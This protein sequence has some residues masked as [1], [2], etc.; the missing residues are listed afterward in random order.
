MKGFEYFN[1]RTQ[2]PSKERVMEPKS[3]EGAEKPKED[4]SAL[5]EKIGELRATVQ[6]QASQIEALVK[7]GQAAAPAPKA[8]PPPKLEPDY[9]FDDTAFDKALSEAEEEGEGMTPGQIMKLAIG[10]LKGDILS[11]HIAPLQAAGNQALSEMQRQLV[12]Q[13][14]QW[15]LYGPNGNAEVTRK[16]DE[17][18]AKVDPALK[19]NPEVLTQI[20]NAAVGGFMDAI[21]EAKVEEALRKNVEGGDEKTP[22]T[23]GRAPGPGGGPTGD[24]QKPTVEQFAGHDGMLA[25]S[26]VGKTG[27][28]GDELAQGLGYESWD[29][30]MESYEA[31]LEQYAKENVIQ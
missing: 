13:S 16:V 12:V 28:S 5:S 7:H 24:T 27:K 20:Y 26:H 23:P 4:M 31:D 1:K 22:P 14:G 9:E 17:M 8:D 2:T 3:E 29:H 18:L 11:K 10:K 19:T 21:V 15:P 30:Y 25:L 6:A